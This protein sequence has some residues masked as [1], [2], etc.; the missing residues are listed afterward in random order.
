MI[1]E[2]RDKRKRMLAI[3]VLGMFV[4]MFM[5]FFRLLLAV[6]CFLIALPMSVFYTW[7][8]RKAEEKLE[9]RYF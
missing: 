7:K 1:E 2:Y 9:E 6:I 5:P 4:I 3:F 8:K